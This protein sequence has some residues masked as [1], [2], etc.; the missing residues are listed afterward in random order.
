MSGFLTYCL[1]ILFVEW[2]ISEGFQWYQITPIWVLS[3]LWSSFIYWSQLVHLSCLKK[4]V[5]QA[6]PWSFRINLVSIRTFRSPFFNKQ[7]TFGS[8][9][10]FWLDFRDNIK[11]VIDIRRTYFWLTFLIDLYTP[12]TIKNNN[13]AIFK[14]MKKVKIHAISTNFWSWSQTNLVL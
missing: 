8:K 4:L 3:D 12:Y 2:V 14:R 1:L 6:P 7:D 11:Q 10:I 5:T 9:D 13:L